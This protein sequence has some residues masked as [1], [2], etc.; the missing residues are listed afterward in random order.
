MSPELLA[1]AAMIILVLGVLFVRI[2]VAL[3]LALL[4]FG[5]Y[6]VLDGFPRAVSMVGNEL[7]STFSSYGLTVIP[8][9]I[10]MGQICFH[11]GMSSRLYSAVYAWS[12]HCRGGIALA[13]LLA[14][15]GFSAICGSNTATAAT[16]SSV[17]LPEM[18]KYGY[19]PVLASGTVAAGTTLGAVIPPSVVAIV[20]GVQ[21]SSSIERLFLGGIVPGLVLLG[22]F[23]VSLAVIAQLHPHWAPAGERMPLAAKIRAT[24]GLVETGLLFF[25]VIF[26]LSNG[27]F[28]PTEAGAAGAGLALIIGFVQR[29]LS[30]RGFIKALDESLRISAMIFLL[31]AGA[32]MF[33]KFLTLTRVPFTLAD[34]IAG[35]AVPAPLVLLLVALIYLVGGMIMDA[36][37]L[38]MITIPIFFP[39]A[40]SLG[41]DTLWFSIFLIIITTMG[42]ITPPVGV[43]AYVVST[44]SGQDGNSRVPLAQVFRGAAYFLP[45]FVVCLLA[46][47]AFPDLAVWLPNLIQPLQ[48]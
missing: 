43:S 45:A 42:A 16:M 13:T 5:G 8:L 19:H 29:S 28:T 12:G 25:L 18:R 11:S 2:P 27:L 14:C 38:L 26:G 24:P 9:F 20:V 31:M 21:T 32:A 37:A 44:M 22:L 1:L 34:W 48:G 30:F 33:G 39:L 35:L 40:E 23:L 4:G 17:A 15:G 3:L 6:I 7:W 41:W 46:M 10:L 36:L 47:W